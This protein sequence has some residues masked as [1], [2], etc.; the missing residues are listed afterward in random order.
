MTTNFPSKYF[1]LFANSPKEDI[2]RNSIN[3]GLRI[4][5]TLLMEEYEVNVLLTEEAIW[6]ATN[7]EDMKQKTLDQ[8]GEKDKLSSETIDAP[9]EDD[10]SFTPYELIEGIISFGGN[11]M[12][13]RS[14]LA[15]TGLKEE[16]II[17]GVELIHL[18]NA[19]KLMVQ[20]DKA[21]VF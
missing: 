20:C 18:H 8:F 17:E 1:L 5:L 15:L 13:C 3:A 9:D 6:L 14:S 16:D 2:H 4:G 7:P 12:T 21:F 11:V 19:I 10:V